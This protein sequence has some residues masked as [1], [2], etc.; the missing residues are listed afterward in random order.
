MSSTPAV[1]AEPRS[2]STI[3]ARSRTDEPTDGRARGCARSP[4]SA[5][6]LLLA[7]ALPLALACIPIA[8]H[9]DRAPRTPRPAPPTIIVGANECVESATQAGWPLIV[10]AL[11]VPG[12]DSTGARI[13][14]A[15]PTLVVRL[16]DARGT[17]VP[18]A[19]AAIPPVAE[20]GGD[21]QWCWLAGEGDTRTLASGTYTI[22][23]DPG[24]VTVVLRVVTGTL[25]VGAA[26]SPDDR[27]RKILRA[28][29]ALAA[30]H[31][32]EAVAEA[33]RMIAA[34]STDVSA[35]HLRVDLL[36]R[37]GRSGDALTA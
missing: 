28:Q 5:R 24:A 32:D 6:P 14:P 12:T 4:A 35:W 33:D 7:C 3:A 2:A 26:G 13:V 25:V 8:T 27:R 9:A 18:L 29:S 36:M 31:D 21:T 11:L 37:A 19:L 16:L 34:D 23:A 30:G 17:S 10:T 22:T 15:T 20:E 1:T